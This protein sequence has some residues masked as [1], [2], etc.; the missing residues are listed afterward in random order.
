MI[1]KRYMSRLLLGFGAVL[2]LAF[3]VACSSAEEGVTQEELAAA[4]Q[5][6]VAG[7]APAPA[8]AP[9]GP[10][11]AEIS[12]LVSDAVAASAPA[13]VSSADIAAA[14]EAAVASSAGEAVT[15]AEIQ[16]LVGK[17][18]EGAVMA[19]PSP[20]SASE[21]QAI[22]SSAIAAIPTPVPLAI[23]VAPEVIAEARPINVPAPKGKVGEI[24]IAISDVAPGV[25]LGS[26]QVADFMHYMG[27]GEVTFMSVE[28]DARA[29]MLATAW[30]L[31]PD[32]SGGTLTI[33]EGVIFHGQGLPWADNKSWGPMT[34]RDIAYT[35]NEGN[36]SI[37]NASI[38]WQAGDF[39]TM[40]GANPIEVIDD[41]TLA[42]TF[43]TLPDGSPIFDI[44]WNAGLLNDAAQAFSVQ[45]LALNEAKGDKW[46]IDNPLISTGPYH[47]I[48]W[49]QDDIG[50]VEPV[51]YDHWL[52]NS[53]MDRITFREVTEESTKV[54]LMETGEIDA[55]SITLKNLPSMLAGGFKTKDNGLAFM[56]A[57]I[58]SGNL[59]ETNNIITDAPLD[60]AAVYMRDVPW[61]GNPGGVD[62]A[63]T[64]TL[65]SAQAS[66]D[67]GTLNDFEEAILVRNALARAIDREAINDSLLNG[68]GF[69]IWNQVF[70]P[71]NENWQS[72]WEFPFDPGLAE[73]MLDDS[74]N[75][76]KGGKRF[77]IPLF[78]P[79]FLNF[80]G[81]EI[82]D[83]VSGF[84]DEIG[85]VT[86]VQKFAYSVYRPTIV[87]RATTLPWVTPGDDGKS[88]WPWDWP[89]A[90][91]HT[92][93][94]R[95]G[96]GIGVEIPFMA[97][98]WLE[99]AGEPDIAKR[100]ALNNLVM[101][102]M[103]E[104]AIDVG[105]VALPSPITYN[106]NSIADWPMDPGLFASINKHEAIVPATR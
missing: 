64:A 22:V 5:Q 101:D 61:V 29:P 28:G 25:G 11:A 42:F 2:A 90:Q 15:A 88:T 60:T 63:K 71:T 104:M 93:L 41:T 40:F 81:Q 59:W 30:T 50:I 21:I 54:A 1:G 97:E 14:V 39:A 26:A 4:L 35:I 43:S 48:E 69:P 51:P 99:I 89:K 52:I 37:N 67:A 44:R 49:T 32:V 79:D 6:A 7:A 65:A 85:V 76:M 13:G 17:A 86:Q 8:P 73:R 82:A 87:A 92:S 77:E 33:R 103:F 95:G 68:L 70:S 62:L 94:T 9:A 12:K 96:Y 74:G 66:A 16:A 46:M 10:S 38:H 18:V 55:A 45:S 106:P 27:V 23:A 47:I 100:I 105:V 91:D 84:W 75:I 19:G 56:E 83:A 31:K 78:G 80:A 36:G 98:K 3:V 72:K 20:L 34:A 53:Q 24:V 102:Y 57:V 58:F